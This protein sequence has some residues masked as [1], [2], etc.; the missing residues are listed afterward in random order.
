MACFAHLPNEVLE[1]VFQ[2]LDFK[3][4][5]NLSL[6]CS[7]WNYVLLSERYLRKHAILHIEG[8]RVLDGKT[9]FRRE[10]EALSIKLNRQYCNEMAKNLRLIYTICASPVYLR[11]ENLCTDQRFGLIFDTVYFSHENIENLHLIGTCKTEKGFLCSTLNNLKVLKVESNYVE[12]FRLIAPN[13]VELYLYV[14]SEE[15]MDLLPQF[16]DQLKKLD[17]VF[18]S[19]DIYYLYNLKFPHITDLSVDRKLKGMTKSEQDI[20]I[21][22]YKR[23]KQLQKLKLSVKFIDSYVMQ[24]ISTS[25]SNLTE[26]TLQVIEGTIELSNISKLVNLEKLTIEAEKVNLLDAKFP[27]LKQLLLGSANFRTG[28][29]V[30]AFESLMVFNK[31]RVLALHNVKFYPE[32]LKL[33]PSYNVEKLFITNF[34]RLEETHL[35][36]LIKRFPAIRWLKIAHCPGFTQREVEKIKRMNPKMCVAFDEVS[37]GR[38]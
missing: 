21:A 12:Y 26:L 38:L 6:V 27:R 4:R 36:I 35:Q 2:Y 19:K 29:Y 9:Q 11:V 25:I 22:F 31:M 23:F 28:T 8:C 16:A 3:N 1:N 34:K 15:H 10:Y 17:I 7:R 32:V 33:T 14:C 20:S 24:M 18:D 30:Y 13:L 5:K 37:Q